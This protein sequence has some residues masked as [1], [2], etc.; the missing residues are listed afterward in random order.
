MFTLLFFCYSNSQIV[1]DAVCLD[2]A[3]NKPATVH[4]CNVGVVCAQWHI[5]SWQPVS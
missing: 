1:D 3:G 4:E 5:G 2:Q